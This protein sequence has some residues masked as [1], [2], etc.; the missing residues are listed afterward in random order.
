MKCPGFSLRRL[1]PAL[2][3]LSA[4]LV[5]VALFAGPVLLITYTAEAFGLL[6]EKRRGIEELEV[7]R[8]LLLRRLNDKARDLGL[9][10]RI[11]T[12]RNTQRFV[13]STH[14]S[15]CKAFGFDA[16]T[17]PDCPDF[18]R[19]AAP[20]W[21]FYRIELGGESAPGDLQD[22]LSTLSQ[23]AIRI[24]TL[25]IIAGEGHGHGRWTLG[26][27]LPILTIAEMNETD[28]ADP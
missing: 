15:V 5:L 9:D 14:A 6:K 16:E 17:M 24:E 10:P 28:A 8:A 18:Q 19:Q 21:Q 26:L 20:P 3:V 2:G 1:Q 27:T 22:K 25:D 11:L 13:A 12:E 7:K 23:E 4:G